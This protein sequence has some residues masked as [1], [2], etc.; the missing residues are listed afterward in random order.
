MTN[1]ELF[2]IE[3]EAEAVKKRVF[4]SYILDGGADG[5]RIFTSPIMSSGKTSVS[6]LM[7]V[8]FK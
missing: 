3:D 6:F 7:Q 8:E 4:A 2:D 1:V 5:K